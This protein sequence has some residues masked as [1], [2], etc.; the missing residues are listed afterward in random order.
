M[1]TSASGRFIGRK[2]Y[3]RGSARERPNDRGRPSSDTPT[4]RYTTHLFDLE[5]RIE[6]RPTKIKHLNERQVHNQ[7]VELGV[8]R[9]SLRDSLVESGS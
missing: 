6:H 7:F 1:L 9:Q 8:V 3:G 2:R 5:N 4:T